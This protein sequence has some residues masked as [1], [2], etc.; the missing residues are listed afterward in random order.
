MA[1]VQALI[2]RTQELKQLAESIDEAKANLRQLQRQLGKSTHSDTRKERRPHRS[3]HP[4]KK[5]RHIGA[6]T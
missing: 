2:W 6:N 3:E 1:Q 4:M 5:S